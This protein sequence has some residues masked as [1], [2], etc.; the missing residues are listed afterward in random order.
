MSSIRIQRFPYEEPYHVQLNLSAEN[1]RFSGG[2]DFYTGV[3]SLKE[4]AV[5]L[6]NFPNHI[7]DEIQFVY[8][9]PRKEDRTYR[10]LIIR[11][12]TVGRVGHCS[13]QFTFNNHEEEPD[14]G[15]ARFSI[16]AD[17]AAVNRLGKLLERFSELQHLELLWSPD[18]E[19]L[20]TELQQRASIE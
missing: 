3:H 1:G 7:G 14:E 13:I 18:E 12:Y 8:G 19:E 4:F 6:Q 16:S 15:S 9:S 20:Y 5:T 10:H 11:A 2:F 17:A